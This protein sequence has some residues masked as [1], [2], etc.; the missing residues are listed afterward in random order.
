MR[1]GRAGSSWHAPGPRADRQARLFAC[2]KCQ[3]LI[4]ESQLENPADRSLTKAQKIRLRLGGSP[5]ML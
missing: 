3:G 5:N 4:Y 2:R 1:H